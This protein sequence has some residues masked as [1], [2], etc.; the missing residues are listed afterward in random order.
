M[1]RIRGLRLQ[2]KLIEYYISSFLTLEINIKIVCVS[3]L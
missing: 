1:I 2:T 3:N